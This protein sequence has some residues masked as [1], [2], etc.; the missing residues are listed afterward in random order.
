MLKYMYD[1]RIG[2]D[3]LVGWKL[4]DEQFQLKI[5]MDFVKFWVLVD[6]ELWVMYMVGGQ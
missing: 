6:F 3:R 2:V 5:V 4:Y 1:V